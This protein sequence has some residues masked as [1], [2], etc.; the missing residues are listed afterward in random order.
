[1]ARPKKE[2]KEQEVGANSAP[3]IVHIKPVHQIKDA[4]GNGI[5][6]FDGA[7][8]AVGIGKQDGVYNTEITKKEYEKIR[9]DGN[10]YASLVGKTYHDFLKF[11]RVHIPS[12][13]IILHLNSLQHKL[14]YQVLKDSKRIANTV[15]EVKPSY[16][17]YYIHNQ[18]EE[19]E[20]RRNARTH[21]K[22]AFIMMDKMSPEEMQDLL[23][24]LGTDLRGQHSILIEDAL[25]EYI[26]KD[27]E[28]VLNLVEDSSYKILVLTEKILRGVDRDT[29]ITRGTN[30]GFY[31]GDIFL[32]FSRQDI[33][34]YLNDTNHL[35]VYEK[36]AQ[37]FK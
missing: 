15:S 35:E 18:V 6:R 28:E 22:K 36:L 37:M 27:P 24:L 11:F 21:R 17:A 34:Q 3:T 2:V 32:G 5:G 8:F 7:R 19:A 26:E 31:Y 1:M 9:E 33:I 25:G 20:V 30:S 13:G 10:S 14:W 12:S 16:H 23:L 29:G 4:L